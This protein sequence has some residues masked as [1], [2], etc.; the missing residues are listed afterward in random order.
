MLF[1]KSGKSGKLLDMSTEIVSSLFPEES[2]A[3]SARNLPPDRNPVLIY[4]GTLAPGSRDT[5]R[6]ALEQV[7]RLS[8]LQISLE[9]FPWWALR[10]QH[11]MKI[12]TDLCAQYAPA[13]VNKTLTALRQVF[14]HCR[15]LK[16]M[17]AE[18]CAEASDLPPARG[19]RLPTG[20]A[21]GLEEIERLLLQTETS[22]VLG[23]RN[24]AIV[25]LLLG[26]GLRRAEAAEL[27]LDQCDFAQKTLRIIG[28]GNKEREVPLNAKVL[29]ALQQWLVIR[30]STPG[31]LFYRGENK[32]LLHPGQG[33][34][35]RGI[36]SILMKLASSAAL[37]GPISP[38]DFRRTY[39]SALLDRGKDLAVVADLAGHAS[40]DTTRQYDRRGARAKRDA[41][42]SLGDLFGKASS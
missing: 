1:L 15:R 37:E 21:L 9:K 18:Q 33:I 12:R 20:R 39:I 14:R 32:D 24:R 34:S 26:A 6:T 17:T 29:G 22:P 41:A 27:Q 8:G 2:L 35:P 30:G 3:P 28:K 38:H 16:L 25:M 19:R 40:T 42:D 5:L 7:V 23:V 4:L 31:P 10:Y 13:T 11:V 36:Y